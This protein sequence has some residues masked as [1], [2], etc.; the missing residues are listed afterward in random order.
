M[1][2]ERVDRGTDAQLEKFIDDYLED[3]DELQVVSNSINSYQVYASKK[4]KNLT[5]NSDS[6]RSLN[7]SFAEKKLKQPLSVI[8]SKSEDHEPSLLA[9]VTAPLLKPSQKDKSYKLQEGT[10][11]WSIITTMYR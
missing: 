7:D 10:N 5:A 4:E 8:S 2:R 11:P 6:E 1:Q 9:R 3:Q